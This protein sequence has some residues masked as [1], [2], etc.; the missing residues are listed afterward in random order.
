M[1]M[2]WAVLTVVL[3]GPARAGAQVPQAT[4]LPPSSGDSIVQELRL[5][6]QAIERQSRGSARVELLVGR[7]T[8]QDQRVARTQDAADRL[9]DEA[10][11]LEQQRRRMDADLRD[12]TRAFEQEADDKRR[13]DL[14]GQ[15]R[16]T[17]TR[18]TEHNTVYAQI[19]SRRSRARQ[20]AM[21][22]QTRSRELDA[23]LAELERE[24]GRDQ[25]PQR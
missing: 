15:I 25:G 24:L 16:S 12:L 14:E 9:D 21:E 20:A 3:V 11:T 10:F 2:H 1:R 17:R 4:P 13:T 8:V 5:L 22:E 19:E 7:L 18:I 6:R 23:R